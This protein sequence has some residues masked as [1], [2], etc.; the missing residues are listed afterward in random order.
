MTFFNGGNIASLLGSVK[1]YI[2]VSLLILAV[3]VSSI[4]SLIDDGW[5]SGLM[6]NVMF[7]G[8]WVIEN[9]RVMPEY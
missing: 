3:H 2:D 8:F 6:L 5:M 7:A 9:T 4:K 1:L